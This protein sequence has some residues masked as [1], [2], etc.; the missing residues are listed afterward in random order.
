VDH[1]SRV[2]RVV[3]LEVEEA[4]GE[5]GATPNKGAGCGGERQAGGEVGD[6]DTRA[7][8]TALAGAD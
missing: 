2:S 4:T 6:R 7:R 8:D 3:K 5:D 1:E